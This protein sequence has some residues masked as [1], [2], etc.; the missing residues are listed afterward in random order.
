MAR[1]LWLSR[2]LYSAV[3]RHGRGENESLNRN[4]RTRQVHAGQSGRRRSE[5][6]STGIAAK[7]RALA[8]ATHRLF[9]VSG[10]LPALLLPPRRLYP[11]LELCPD[12]EN[13]RHFRIPG[14]CVRRLQ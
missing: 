13:R 12:G 1:R 2:I 9:G 8:A 6:V 4:E 7:R 14:A 3:E 5:S 10:L 11:A